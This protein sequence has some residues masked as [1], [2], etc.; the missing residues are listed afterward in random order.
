MTLNALAIATA[1]IAV[2]MSLGS[3]FAGPAGST[4]DLPDPVRLAHMKAGR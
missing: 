3:I 2:V 4:A 1:I